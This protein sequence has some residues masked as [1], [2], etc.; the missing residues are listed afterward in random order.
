MIDPITGSFELMHYNNKKSM[1]IWN[2]VGTTWLVRYQW[3]VEIMHEQGGEFLGHGF[4][5]S[6]IEQ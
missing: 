6:L 1:T 4:K 5:T 2:L 3:P